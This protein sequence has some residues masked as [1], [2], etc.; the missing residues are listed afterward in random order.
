[1]DSMNQSSPTPSAARSRPP[2]QLNEKL[3]EQ[4][5][6]RQHNKSKSGNIRNSGAACSMDGGDLR[7]LC[8]GGERSWEACQDVE[9]QDS[10]PS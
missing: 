4:Q 10:G 5:H 9:F 8:L 7:G 3:R 2:S 6:S 1:M